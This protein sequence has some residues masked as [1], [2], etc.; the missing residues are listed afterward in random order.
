MKRIISIHQKEE[1]T[2]LVSKSF[3][4]DFYHTWTFH[5][6]DN[7][8]S[9]PFLFVFEEEHDFIAIPFLKRKVPGTVYYD[10]SSVYGFVGPIAN[11]DFE[12]LSE[13]FINAFKSSFQ[14]FLFDEKIISI[15][16]RLHPFINQSILLEKFGG[17]KNNGKIVVIDLTVPLEIQRAKYPKVYSKLKQL[18]RKGYHLK[19][20]NTREDVKMFLSIYN[21]NMSRLNASASYIFSEEDV[22]TLLNAKEYDAKLYFINN[23]NGLPICGTIIVI[24]NQLIQGYLIA[25]RQEYRSVSPAKLL[26]D[27]ITIIGRENGAKYYNLG[28]GVSYKEDTLFQWKSIFS[29]LTLPH[30]SWRYIVDPTAYDSVIKEN[31]IENQIDIDFFP[32]YRKVLK[33]V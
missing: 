10:L 29:E 22:I 14:S 33:I 2:G 24:T 15:F 11:K 9:P 12:N 23:E 26:V 7:T 8:G 27:E 16:C 4:Y 18:K 32:L 17:I 6:I 30:K 13:K 20:G 28:G 21:E 5:F 19:E 31:K 1:W 25:T 3:Y